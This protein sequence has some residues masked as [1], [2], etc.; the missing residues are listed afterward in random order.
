MAIRVDAS[1]TARMLRES[2]WPHVTIVALTADEVLDSI[3]TARRHGVRGGAIYDYMH[4][5]AARKA[6]TATLH[7]LNLEDFLHLR[8]S[9]DPEI[10]HP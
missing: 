10:R 3:D 6:N 1:V 7:T 9:G 2:I 4:L 8:R 5:V